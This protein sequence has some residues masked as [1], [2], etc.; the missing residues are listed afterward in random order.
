MQIVSYR[1]PAQAGGVS[2]LIRSALLSDSESAWWHLKSQYL[3]AIARDKLS[4]KSFY[5]S[6]HHRRTL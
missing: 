4:H 5:S 3:Q 6:E 1:G 2:A